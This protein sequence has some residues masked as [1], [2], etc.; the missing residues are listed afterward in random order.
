MEA[1]KEDA[2]GEVTQPGDV[3]RPDEERADGEAEGTELESPARSAEREHP[4]RQVT[5]R[6]RRRKPKAPS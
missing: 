4:P 2:L 1:L 6:T 5:H 3:L